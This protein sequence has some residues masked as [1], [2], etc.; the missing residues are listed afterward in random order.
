MSGAPQD[1]SQHWLAHGLDVGD[2][3]SA[4]DCVGESDRLLPNDTDGDADPL[5]ERDTHE[6]TPA[7]QTTTP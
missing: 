4:T 1:G 7:S 3:V 2:G 5:G 6:Q